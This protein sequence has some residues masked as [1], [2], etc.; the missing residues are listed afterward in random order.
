MEHISAVLNCLAAQ[1]NC[2]GEPYDQMVEASKYI[3]ELE[4]KLSLTNSKLL[5][6]KYDLIFND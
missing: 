6:A 4:G 1:E 5:Q 3:C 2:D